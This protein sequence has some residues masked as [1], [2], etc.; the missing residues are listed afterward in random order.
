MT[1]SILRPSVQLSLM[2]LVAA[3][4]RFPSL[5]YLSLYGDEEHTALAVRAILADGYP[6]MPS[7][8][9][10]WRG[11]VYSY[12]AA[13]VARIWGLDEWALRLPSALMGLLAVPAFYGLSRR[14]LGLLGGTLAAWLLVVSA[15]HV[16]L[17]REARMYGLFLTAGLYAL[18]WFDRG[19]L[20]QERRYRWL[21]VFA[22]LVA[23]AS[24][25]LA[26]LLIGMWLIAALFRLGKWPWSSW[27]S[28]IGISAGLLFVWIWVR[29][30]TMIV[31]P[32]TQAT[33]A[34]TEDG[35]SGVLSRFVPFAFH[36]KFWMLGDMLT[37]QPALWLGMTIVSLC[38][39]WIAY[40]YWRSDEGLDWK[41]WILGTAIVAFAVAN[42]FG[43]V[44]W[45]GFACA[46]WWGRSL[47]SL[48]RLRYVQTLLIIVIGIF[49]A[50]MGYALLVWRGGMGGVSSPLQ[51]VARAL[52]DA[53]YFPALHYLVYLET[54]PV[55][56]VL[57]VGAT[58][59]WLVIRHRGW[60]RAQ[61]RLLVVLWFWVPL[62]VLGLMREWI[63]VRYSLPVYPFFLMLAAWA[64]MLLALI[65]RWWV[66]RYGYTIVGPQVVARG[67]IVVMG[68][69]LLGTPIGSQHNLWA[70]WHM[71]TLDYGESSPRAFHGYPSHPDHRNPGQYVRR[72]RGPDDLV[73]A[74]DVFQQAYYVGHV[75][76]WLRPVK[77]AY[78]YCRKVDGAL[79][80][81][82]VGARVLGSAADLEALRSRYPDRTMWLITSSEEPELVEQ[83][84]PT[85]LRLC[86]CA[87]FTGRDGKTQVFRLGPKR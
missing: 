11:M 85:S 68:V 47:W 52:K 30:M 65:L 62:G 41:A 56:A 83:L 2:M 44:L 45:T 75:D 71:A 15:W 20:G 39:L 78:S 7:G 51:I 64:V 43:L 10:Y 31:S 53:L 54:F 72:H 69:L 60:F 42:L 46:V 67:T 70:A 24:H 36:P 55:L 81:L 27:I 14:Y 84:L 35:I 3:L 59:G 28:V 18:W 63:A 49:S 50:W 73:V 33:P 76:Y 66:S 8:M 82:Y 61:P 57:V 4:L 16:D 25:E 80:D 17:S 1:G 23:I 38:A 58:A 19:F 32:L 87:E 77:A 26:V 13:G 21:A 37:Q 34:V 22:M 86:R 40:A 6:H 12:L 5:G 29:R 9:P 79:I 48:V 74:M